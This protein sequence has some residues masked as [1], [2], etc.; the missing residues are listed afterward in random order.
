MR[1]MFRGFQLGPTLFQILLL[2]YL[3]LNLAGAGSDA[4]RTRDFQTL[5]TSHLKQIVEL[6]PAE[7]KSVTEGHLGKLLIPRACAF[8]LLSFSLS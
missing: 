7:W 2:L 8:L 5:S 3:S 1:V 6:P 4:F